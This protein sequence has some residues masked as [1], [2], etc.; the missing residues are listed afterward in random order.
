MPLTITFSALQ[1]Q[2]I[3]SL[4]NLTNAKDPMPIL[5]CI[6]LEVSVNSVTAFATDRY[7]MG[8]MT[9]EP[10]SIAL[11]EYHATQSHSLLLTPEALKIMKAT[12]GLLTVE[13]DSELRTISIIEGSNTISGNRTVLQLTPF[14]DVARY[15]ATDKLSPSKALSELPNGLPVPVPSD[16]PLSLSL[17][18]LT[19]VSKV[20]NPIQNNEKNKNWQFITCGVTENNNKH[21]KPLVLKRLSVLVLVMPLRDITTN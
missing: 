1:A 20:L 18:K 7:L 16:V 11:G 5:S 14:Y 2:A 3:A 17:D 6:K 9:F 4:V 8:E 12:K 10:L 19:K 13:F 21:L 15:P